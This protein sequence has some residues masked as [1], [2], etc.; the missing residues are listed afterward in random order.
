MR[1]KH[2]IG[3]YFLQR[4]NYHGGTVT[5]ENKKT[6]DYNDEISEGTD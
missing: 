6:E 4:I 3:C 5:F 2:P 1:L